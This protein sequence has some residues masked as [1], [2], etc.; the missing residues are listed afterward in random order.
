MTAAMH[1]IEY[2]SPIEYTPPPPVLRLEKDAWPMVKLRKKA[3][4][5][6]RHHRPRRR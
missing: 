2:I 1:E 6:Y 4:N 3:T 5:E